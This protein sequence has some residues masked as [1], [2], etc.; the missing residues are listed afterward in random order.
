M[1]GIERVHT[2]HFDQQNDRTRQYH[3]S[4]SS[5]SLS[6]SSVQESSRMMRS[7]RFAPNESA[8]SSAENPLS[9]CCEDIRDLWYSTE[10]LLHFREQVRAIVLYGR[11]KQRQQQQT[12]HVDS[13]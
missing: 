7:V 9:L 13:S 6:S 8:I 4:S 10:E 5:S 2:L 12:P 3:C 11:S 1:L